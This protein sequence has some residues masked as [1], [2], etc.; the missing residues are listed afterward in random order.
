MFT[1]HYEVGGRGNAVHPSLHRADVS[2]AVFQLDVSDHHV[3]RGALWSKHNERAFILKT[4]STSEA[5]A[6]NTVPEG[7]LYS[8]TRPRWGETEDGWKQQRV[9][10][11]RNADT[12]FC[13]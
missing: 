11:H 4:Q 7:H 1:S 3:A 6:T 5:V 9:K 8:E 12:G 10:P 13:S 2:P